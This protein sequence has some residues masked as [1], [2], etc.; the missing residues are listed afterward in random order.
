MFMKRRIAIA[1]RR[2][3]WRLVRDEVLPLATDSRGHVMSLQ[4]HVRGF[5]RVKFCVVCELEEARDYLG[6][7]FALDRGGNPLPAAESAARLRAPCPFSHATAS[8][9]S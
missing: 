4:A 5:A 7:R 2:E 3:E 9:C 6:N 8:G 1:P